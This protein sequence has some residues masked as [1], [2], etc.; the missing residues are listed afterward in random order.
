MSDKKLEDLKRKLI[1]SVK[2][3]AMGIAIGT[4][5]MAEAYAIRDPELGKEGVEAISDATTIILKLGN[6]L[7]KYLTCLL[8]GTENAPQEVKLGMAV[9]M[10]M[11]L[12]EMTGL[13]DTEIL[14]AAGII[15]PGESPKRVASNQN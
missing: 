12:S 7:D 13:P 3:T 11:I 8:E 6:G 9:A 5:T 1:D 14:K 2:M 4:A 10:A 15:L